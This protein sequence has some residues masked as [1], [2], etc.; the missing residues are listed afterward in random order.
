MEPGGLTGSSLGRRVAADR[1]IPNTYGAELADL[2]AASGGILGGVTRAV[3]GVHGRLLADIDSLFDTL[4][5][6]ASERGLDGRDRARTCRRCSLAQT[7][8]GS[9]GSST[10]N[11]WARGASASVRRRG[12]R[13]ETARHAR[14]AAGLHRR[15]AHAARRLDAQRVCRAKPLC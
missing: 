2:V 13:D 1:R 15:V 9:R 8:Q 3:D 10:A 11:P 6:L 7:V 12:V 4:L 14:P 5:H